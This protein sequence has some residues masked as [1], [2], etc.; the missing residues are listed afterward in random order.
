LV[1]TEI[2]YQP[3]QGSKLEF[4]ELHNPEPPHQ[5]LT[6]WR[7][8]GEIKYE[9]PR[10]AQ[11]R[12]G[13]CLVVAADPAAFS[14]VYPGIKNLFGPFSG[15]LKNSGGKIVLRNPARAAAAE[16]E[17][18]IGE[19]WT[20]IPQGTGHS[21]EIS[22][23]FLDPTDPSSWIASV[24]LGG[25][26]GILSKAQNYGNQSS[27]LSM[28]TE[29]PKN[30]ISTKRFP[31]KLPFISE[32]YINPQEHNSEFYDW[33]ELSNDSD[34][35]VPTTD[36]FLSDDPFELEKIPLKKLKEIPERGFLIIGN[37]DFPLAS[38]R[39]DRPTFL[40]SSMKLKVLDRYPPIRKMKS[41]G[42]DRSFG[43]NHPREMIYPLSQKTPGRSN[44]SLE[45]PSLII[46]EIH[47]HPTSEHEGEEFIE[48]YNRGNKNL[49][50]IGYQLNSG[51][52]YLFKNGDKIPAHGFVVVA[53][54]PSII[55]DRY[56]LNESLVLG[57]Y[58]GNLSHA[59]ETIRLVNTAGLLIDQVKYS[60]GSPWPEFADGWGN[61]IELI[62]PNLDNRH[63]AS[64]QKS[65][66]S[67]K[68]A[69]Q[70]IRYTKSLKMAYIGNSYS[71]QLLLLN[72][73]SCLIDEFRIEDENQQILVSEDFESPSEQW[74]AVGTH[75]E[76]NVIS[77][78]P[79]N[80]SSCLKL[81]ALGRGNSRHNFVSYSLQKRL[82][83][84]QVYTISFKVRWL[85][86]CPLLLTRTPGQGLAST[87][88]LNIPGQGATPSVA[89]TA[90]Q[91][92]PR[93]AIGTP[94]QSPVL[95]TIQETVRLEIPISSINRIESAKVLFRHES[96]K[97]WSSIELNPILEPSRPTRSSEGTSNL[98]F[99]EI[100]TQPRGR[101][102]FIITAKDVTGNEGAFPKGAPLK[103]A[104]YASGLKVD[105]SRIPIYTLLVTDKE[106]QAAEQRPKMSNKLMD[107]TLVYRDSIIRY[108]V[109]L[110]RRGS[111]FT[112]SNDN[113]RVVFGSE[114]IDGR[115]SLTLDGQ[116]GDVRNPK[117][118]LTYWL[119]DSLHAPNSRQKFVE[120]R[121]PGFDYEGGLYEEVEKVDGDYLARWFKESAFYD[122]SITDRIA[123]NSRQGLLHKIDDYWELDVASNSGGSFRGYGRN[124]QETYF[125]YQ[126][127]DPEFYRWNFPPRAEGG[128]ENFSP[129]LN[130][131][132][133]MDPSV[134]PDEEFEQIIESMIQVDEWLRV[135]AARTVAN[136]WD[137]MGRHRGKN[138]FIYRS[139]VDQ[140]WYLV[141]WDADLTWS[142]RGRYGGNGLISW[143]FPSF[144]RLL[145]IPKYRRTFYSYISYLVTRPLESEHFRSVLNQFSKF[146]GTDSESFEWFA[147]SQRSDILYQI[148]NSTFQITNMSRTA[149]SDRKSYE[150]ELSGT[151]PPIAYDIKLNNLS[152]TVDFPDEKSWKATFRVSENARN[153]H[154]VFYDFGENPI[155][156][157]SFHLPG[158]E[159]IPTPTGEN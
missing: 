158:Q 36:L 76:S 116:R 121:F 101:V 107:A 128:F 39:S 152:G 43:K 99:G 26:P 96:R 112:R 108:N 1:F 64:W 122:D 23:P 52:R 156:D 127:D 77:P 109:G 5:N 89:N 8:T 37:D 42:T 33:I 70:E 58:Q 31:V 65:N 47:Y 84:D 7:I 25:S 19:S 21:L 56:G 10:N 49:E 48:L 141:P 20:P 146:V 81:V 38:L 85:E 22:D 67:S 136:D 34:S 113:W 93:P 16:A 35:S 75:D 129:L 40:T 88:R 79:L 142:Q 105:P 41:D 6:G 95:P 98:W 53:R 11:I 44:E 3:L 55:R 78:G 32:V 57:P 60:D 82:E 91:P 123:S 138:T 124:Y 17:Y 137:T 154:L 135:I 15:K 51:I 117:E 119:I 143:K 73:G 147:S 131:I 148:P 94:H 24:S 125:R 115:G 74:I 103:T 134:T 46:N 159:Q 100:P 14:K 110:R 114:S 69:W 2:H 90:Y 13:E 102:E 92:N 83:E 111:P 71:F 140:L 153:L 145:T 97:N 12:T 30:T 130:L 104:L 54:N 9:F 61:S 27:D 72:S 28:K 149:F 80:R 18:G 86:G 151:A 29:L 68:T 120:V 132:R 155:K 144:E 50:L 59:G 63:P 87:H 118:R 66:L 133:L 62:H 106:W 4:I 157:L 45:A 139:P 126:S 150:L